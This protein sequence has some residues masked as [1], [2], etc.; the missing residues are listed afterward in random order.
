[1]DKCYGNIA[2]GYKAYEKAGLGLSDHDM[3]HLMPKYKQKKPSLIKVKQWTKENTDTLRA[4]L[5]CTDWDVFQLVQKLQNMPVNPHLC[6]WISD[7]MRARPQHVKIR[8]SFSDLI[9][10][11]TVA[12]QGCVLSPVLF[13]LYTSDFNSNSESCS[14]VKYADDTSLT[15]LILKNNETNYRLEMEPFVQWC[16]DNFLTLNI[17]KTQEL[18][19]DFRKIRQGIHPVC[20]KNNEVEIVSEYKYLGTIIDNK[21]DWNKNTQKMCA[22]ANQRLYFLRK[23]RSFNVRD[24]ILHIHSHSPI[25][26][27]P[28]S[29]YSHKLV[30]TIFLT[31]CYSSF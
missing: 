25:R 16:D 24:S 18:V 17:T 21:L 30:Q 28:F 8:T 2:D 5:E 29:L 11:N 10:T 27:V 15:G 23:L 9:F 31:Q 4:C 3:V 1:M 13:T 19:F 12:P 22:K 6:L 7:F 14:L 20:I 26:K